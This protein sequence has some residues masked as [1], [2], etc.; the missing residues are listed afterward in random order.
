[1]TTLAMP[2]TPAAAGRFLT[3]VGNEIRKGLLFA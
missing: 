1:M 2:K 3:A